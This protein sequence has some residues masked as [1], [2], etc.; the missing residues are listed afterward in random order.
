M[1][2]LQNLANEMDPFAG[3]RSQIFS[4]IKS[5]THK[6]MKY[7]NYPRCVAKSVLPQIE[8]KLRDSLF[9]DGVT[10][11]PEEAFIITLAYLIQGP[12]YRGLSMVFHDH[13][14][15]LSKKV[16]EA[17]LPVLAFDLPPPRVRKLN[18][19]NSSF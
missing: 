7:T 9:A 4:L 3:I 10:Y 6:Y 17:T 8:P 18:L 19:N 16:V 2:Y 11:D 5:Q 12:D 1:A 15:L 14:T 13:D